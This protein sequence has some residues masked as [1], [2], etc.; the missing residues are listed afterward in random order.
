KEIS[1]LRIVTDFH[2]P[3]VILDL[4]PK[5]RHLDRLLLRRQSFLA[6]ET[7]IVECDQLSHDT[8]IMPIIAYI[9]QRMIG[10]DQDGVIGTKHPD[11]LDDLLVCAISDDQMSIQAKT[12]ES[13]DAMLQRR[14]TLLE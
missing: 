4:F 11:F 9:G 5:D 14:Q 6:I 8:V 7:D 3:I 12:L 1:G 10:I 2:M 13:L